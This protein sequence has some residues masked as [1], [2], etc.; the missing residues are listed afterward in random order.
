MK[1]TDRKW[2][3]FRLG[4][5]CTIA[6]G[7]RLT[8]ANMKSGSRPFVGATSSNNGIT[9][10]VSNT[11]DSLDRNV[12][13][14]NYN[15]SVGYAFYH[16]YEC[17]FT[18]D[19]KRVH[20][21]KYK[22]GRH[23]LQF[24]AVAIAQQAKFHDYGYKFNGERMER[25]N[26]MLPVNTHDEPDYAFMEAY[27]KERENA[28]LARYGAFV[29]G[30]QS[31]VGGGV[32][33]LCKAPWR[34]FRMLDYF[35]YRRGDQKDMN[36]L[37]PGDEILVSARNVENGIKGFYC[38]MKS[39]KRFSGNCITLNNDGDGGVGLAYYQ[40]HDFLL[41]SHVYALYPK[42]SM[43][44]FAQLFVSRCVSMCRPCFSHGHS[45]SLGRLKTLKV[46]LPATSNGKPD[47][48]Y[49]KAFG[50]EI[51]RVNLSKYLDYL[52]NRVA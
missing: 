6:K 25:Q 14:V 18:D 32:E 52:K 51:V 20:L 28:L 39:H 2:K 11:N 13:G 8:K 4:D 49:M 27:V 43:S 45:I 9:N 31:P 38:G 3:P 34:T 50:R 37:P 46:M 1:L 26:I 30:A 42:S 48:A 24:V 23:V 44:R 47:F 33:P 35:D 12:L 5:V 19:V 15:G 7:V 10:W 36:S 29:K 22:D 21:K 40:P 41:D 16:P 17:I